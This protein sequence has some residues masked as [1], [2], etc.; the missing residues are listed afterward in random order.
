MMIRKPAAAS[1][2]D[3]LVVPENVENLSLD[4]KIEAFQKAVLG[5]DPKLAKGPILR[6]FFGPNEMSALWSRLNTAVKK[7]SPSLKQKWAELKKP[8]QDRAIRKNEQK[9]EILALKLTIDDD[10]EWARQ[11]IQVMETFTSTETWAREG[12]WFY[13]GELEQKL[14]RKEAQEHI[15][16]GK[17]ESDEDE[18]GTKVYRKVRKIDRKEV[19]RGT[20]TAMAYNKDL[21]QGEGKQ[22]KKQLADVDMQAAIEAWASASSSGSLSLDGLVNSA[23][24]TVRKRPAGVGLN[25]PEDDDK[26]QGK[27]QGK[28]DMGK[29]DTG[30]GKGKGSTTTDKMASLGMAMAQLTKYEV[31]LQIVKNKLKNNAICK[32][33]KDRV[34]LV[35][36][37]IIARRKVL[38]GFMDSSDNTAILK[39]LNENKKYISKTIIDVLKT[40]QR[41]SKT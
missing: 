4:D 12:E 29:K 25:P 28:T 14:G 38:S 8:G 33:I 18:Q 22:L 20:S 36:K 3:Q 30:T 31:K 24:T 2:S 16:M 32:P 27:G 39:V 37:E 21:K 35:V 13:K 23:P 1:A 9:N 5:Q 6:K 17:Y 7:S 15:D 34:K 40:A 41:I 26:G 19:S 11:S 10:D